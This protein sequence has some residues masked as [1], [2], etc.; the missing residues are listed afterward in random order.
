MD[1][2]FDIQMIN[3][4]IAH[5]SAYEQ[6][7]QDETCLGKVSEASNVHP[8]VLMSFL[9]TEGADVAHIRQNTDGS[10]D[11]GPMQ[12]NSINW[13]TYYDKY[14]IAPI[15]IR[16]DWCVNL[17]VGAKIVREHFD[18]HGRGAI[19]DWDTFYQVAAEYHSRTE[20]YNLAYQEKWIVNFNY[21]L[22]AL[23]E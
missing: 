16:F 2:P 11:I 7:H 4:V 14:A 9:L 18:R 21:V 22:E 5:P 17:V 19:N 1:I 10:Y 12:I 13:K 8:A 23:S 15:S 20:S 3:T 6:H